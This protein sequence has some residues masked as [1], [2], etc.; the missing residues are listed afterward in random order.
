MSAEASSRRI[1]TV[2]NPGFQRN[3]NKNLRPGAAPSYRPV[4]ATTILVVGEGGSDSDR[5]ERPFQQNQNRMRAFKWASNLNWELRAD[6]QTGSWR[7][8]P[9]LERDRGDQ[10]DETLLPPSVG[11][12]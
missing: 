8:R 12:K 10:E 1:R 7:D 2:G 6:A 3:Q 5:R 4:R 9:S 11:K